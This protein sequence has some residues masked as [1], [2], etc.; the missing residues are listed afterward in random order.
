MCLLPTVL[1]PVRMREYGVE[2]IFE[3]IYEEVTVSVQA[4]VMQSYTVPP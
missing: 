3:K 2:G 4:P 1:V